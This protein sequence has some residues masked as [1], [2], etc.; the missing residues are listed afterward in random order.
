MA[1]YTRTKTQT[2]TYA[3]LSLIK[4][5]AK[6]ALRRS[7]NYISDETLKTVV[8]QGLDKKYIK[9]IDIYGVDEYGRCRA[10]LKLAIDWARHQIHI[11]EGRE[12][13]KVGERW[14]NK[15]CVEVDEVTSVFRE[16]VEDQ[17][18]D[19]IWQFTWAD[20]IDIE[21]ARKELGT[22]PA[23]KPEWYGNPEGF[24]T[25]VRPIDEMYIGCYLS[26]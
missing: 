24:G 9:Q 21:K 10:Q 23:T 16:F 12:M 11:K 17:D 14:L 15:A 6:L 19:T 5:Q 26:T 1:T 22:S 25:A 7:L 3:R 13:V 18:L 2:F 4:A 8:D 20:G